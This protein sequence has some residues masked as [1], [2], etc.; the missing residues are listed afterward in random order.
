L[1]NIIDATSPVSINIAAQGL[2]Y[3]I[4]VTAN[5]NPAFTDAIV[6]VTAS[7]RNS[8]NASD[9]LWRKVYK[10]GVLQDTKTAVVAPNSTWAPTYVFTMGQQNVSIM[11][12]AGHMV[13]TTETLDMT[14][15]ITITKQGIPEAVFIGEPIYSPGQV[16]DPTTPVTI[17]YVIQNT[18]STGLIW[19]GLYDLTSPNPNLIA[20]YWEENINSGQNITKT[21]TIVINTNIQAQLLIGHFE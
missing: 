11:I 10:D 4:N 3:I 14:K 16:V 19:G 18:G 20:G 5:P 12:D 7:I 1:A 13:G 17:T 6:T 15:E 8:G 2:A 21:V 9:T